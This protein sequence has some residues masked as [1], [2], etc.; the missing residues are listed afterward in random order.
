MAV[1][2]AVA[3]DGVDGVDA[4]CSRG[5]AAVAVAVDAGV[6]ECSRGV[7][8]VDVGSRHIL[9]GRPVPLLHLAPHQH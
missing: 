6:A 1:G 2:V 7:A 4:E 3:V 8:A 9:S 5:V